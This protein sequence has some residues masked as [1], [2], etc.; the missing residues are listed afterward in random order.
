MLRFADHLDVIDERE[1]AA[2]T[3]PDHRWSS[4]TSTRITT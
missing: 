4:T 1:I 2:E 3:L